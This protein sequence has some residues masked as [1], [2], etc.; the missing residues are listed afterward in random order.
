MSVLKAAGALLVFAALGGVGENLRIETVK[1]E[2]LRPDPPGP[3]SAFHA[4]RPGIDDC[5]ACH[6]P[7]GETGPANCLACHDEIA[8]RI[9][10]RRGFHRDK[11]EN[12]GTCHPEHRGPDEDLAPLDRGEFDHE[13]T[14]FVLEGGHARVKDCGPCHDGGAAVRRSMGRSYLLK[15]ARCSACHASPHPGRQEECLD[16]HSMEGWRSP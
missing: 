13:E 10:E 5:D 3:L 16:C 8:T 14:G 1:V 7:S 2:R 6:V 11:A 15:D 12:C 4:E 9:A